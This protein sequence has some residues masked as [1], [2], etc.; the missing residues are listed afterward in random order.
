[1]K[2]KKLILVAVISLLTIPAINAQTH[3]RDNNCES[4]KRD[5]KKG[6]AVENFKHKM[7]ANKIAYLTDKLDL[8]TQEAQ[9]FWPIFN[10]YE[11]EMIAIRDKMRPKDTTAEGLPQRPDCL[12]MTD[13]EAQNMINIHLKTK[14]DIIDIQDKYS[15]E[16][17]TAIPVQKVMMLFMLEKRY[18]SDVIGKTWKSQKTDKNNG[19]LN[20][21]ER[22]FES[23]K[24]GH[25]KE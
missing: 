16:F 24:A 7:K 18:M 17:Q 5:C 21:N 13:N 3:N 25:H 9:K 11:D 15:K 2:M 22:K 12:K 6:H 4:H 19:K 10:K 20:R 23:R 14:R 8:S 1:M